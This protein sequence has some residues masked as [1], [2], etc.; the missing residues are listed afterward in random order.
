MAR[1]PRTEPLEFST[2]DDVA[3][4][5]RARGGR[6]SAARR[7]ILQTL[8]DAEGP[9]SAELIT[10]RVAEQGPALGQTS[11]YR[12]L[13]SLESLGAVRHVHLGHGPGLYALVGEGEREY[14]TCERCDRVM[15]VE[16]AELDGVRDEV[17]KRF[18]YEARFSHFP[19]SGLCP[20]CARA[21]R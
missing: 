5:I 3:A 1:S 20:D 10:E 21:E 2:V 14:L 18:G 19:I 12:N 16:P 8:F 13:E 6:L 7:L 11:V 4:A 15:S 17:R 9:I